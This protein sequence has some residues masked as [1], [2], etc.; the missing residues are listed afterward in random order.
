[1][2][3]NFHYTA[4]NPWFLSTTLRPRSCSNHPWITLTKKIIQKITRYNDFQIVGSLDGCLLTRVNKSPIRLLPHFCH[5][6]ESFCICCPGIEGK[7]QLDNLPEART[8]DRKSSGI[9][10]PM[11]RNRLNKDPTSS[12]MVMH[13]SSPTANQLIKCCSNCH[14]CQY[15]GLENT[16][17]YQ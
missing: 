15:F 13:Y 10:R 1:M 14:T 16:L 9:D 12:P 7:I 4:Q 6:S 17:P 3:C 2:S 5:N 8:L 11:R